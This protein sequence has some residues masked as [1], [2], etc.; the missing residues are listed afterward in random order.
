[1]QR[2]LGQGCG[3]NRDRINGYDSELVV[4]EVPDLMAIIKDMWISVHVFICVEL[5]GQV[6]LL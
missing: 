4:E 6:N 1:M 5:K 2:K 3:W